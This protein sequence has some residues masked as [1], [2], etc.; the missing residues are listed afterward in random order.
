MFARLTPSAKL[1]PTVE[2]NAISKGVG[3]SLSSPSAALLATVG[4]SDDATTTSEISNAMSGHDKFQFYR[5]LFPSFGSVSVQS[6]EE[7]SILLSRYKN[8]FNFKVAENVLLSAL[9]QMEQYMH[10]Y[11]QNTLDRSCIGDTRLGFHYI[12]DRLTY[13][14][15]VDVSVFS[16]PAMGNTVGL[17]VRLANNGFLYGSAQNLQLKDK[18]PLTNYAHTKEKW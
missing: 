15:T 18:K 5:N 3:A 14:C 16:H 13:L 9:E 1:Y 11:L 8:C 7:R 10:W 4:S 17:T 12:H 2:L 6:D